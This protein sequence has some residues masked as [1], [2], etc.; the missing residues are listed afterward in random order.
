M[1]AA[2][3]MARRCLGTPFKIHGRVPGAGLDCVGLIIVAG[4]SCGGFA[5]NF[6]FTNYRVT[7][8]DTTMID[9]FLA[10]LDEIETSDAKHGDIAIFKVREKKNASFSHAGV[11]SARGMI[12][13]CL[14]SKRVVETAIH[15][16]W[17]KHGW[18]AFRF[19]TEGN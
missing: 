7:T 1:S 4:R 6:D 18:R 10:H 3:S 19:R 2:L 16:D 14:A 15:S 11:L 5:P 17:T 13:A 12:H 9:Q 8:C